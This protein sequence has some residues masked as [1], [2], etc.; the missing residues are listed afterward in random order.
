[1]KD[2]D[3]GPRPCLLSKVMSIAVPA[4]VVLAIW[5]QTGRSGR[6]NNPP[7]AT[8][9]PAAHATELTERVADDRQ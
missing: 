3:A 6:S 4:V 9:L 1:M 2:R 7:T 8:V 5:S